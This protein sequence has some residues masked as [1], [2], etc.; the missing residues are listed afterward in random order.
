MRLRGDDERRAGGLAEGAEEV[1]THPGDVA[2]VIADVIRDGRRV[3]RVILGDARH[4]L[5]GE[6]RADVRSLGVD[7]AADAAEHGD[8][9]AAEAEAGDALEEL[10]GFVATSNAVT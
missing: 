7:A 2:D 8:G 3:A 5:T 4:H 10:H 6:V 1:G 9:G